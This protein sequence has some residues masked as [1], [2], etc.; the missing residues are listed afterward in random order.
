MRDRYDNVLGTD[1]AAA[2]D[3]YVTAVDDFLA[4]QPHAVAGFETAIA[5]DPGFALAHVALGRMRM[6]GADG[7]GARAATAEA[8]R[9]SD[10]LDAQQRSHVNALALLAEGKPADGYRAIRAHVAEHPRDIMVAQPCTS[11][12]GLIGLSGQPGREAEL[13]AYTTSLGPHY[14]DDWWWQTQHAFALCEVGR[15]EEADTLIDRSLDQCSRNAHGAHVRSHI[16]YEAG[17]VDKGIRFLDDWLADYSHAGMMHGHL[18]WHRMLWALEQRD[19]GALWDRIDADIGPGGAEAAPMNVLADTASILFRATLA[20]E[21]VAPERWQALSAYATEY[22]PKPGLSWADLHAALAHAMAGAEE[23]LALI[24]DAPVGPAAAWTRRYA[25][26]FRALAAEDWAEAAEHLA[27]G[28]SDYA[29]VGGS[30]AQRDLLVFA[31]AHA[32]RQQGSHEEARRV[33]AMQ[34]PIH[35]HAPVMASM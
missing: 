24:I 15:I 3:S 32:L 22:F 26:A 28:M 20:G 35:D 5:H 2:R 19:T 13:L 18:S 21:T 11:I 10:G 30:R 27:A 1:S 33:V 23:R 25:K 9:L 8:R 29:R 16:S 6:L 34:R 4:A 14:G 12:Y 31:L 7:P 17:E